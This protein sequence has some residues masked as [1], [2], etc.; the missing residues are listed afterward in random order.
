MKCIFKKG[1]ENMGGSDI[2]MY[3]LF[4]IIALGFGYYNFIIPI[5]KKKQN[6]KDDDK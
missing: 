6:E 5:K 2:F 1:G 4:S 3:V